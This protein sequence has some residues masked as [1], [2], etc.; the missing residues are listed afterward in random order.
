LH[1][2]DERIPLSD[3]VGERSALRRDGKIEHV[4]LSEVSVAQLQSAQAF[5][6]V[7][8]VQNLSRSPAL[9]RRRAR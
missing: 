7:V 4:G 1:R 9:P 3:Q 5:A 2:V 8:T 6:P